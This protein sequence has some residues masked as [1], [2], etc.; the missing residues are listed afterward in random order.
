MKRF[1]NIVY[2]ADGSTA[3]DYTLERVVALANSNQ[4]SLTVVDVLENVDGEIFSPDV[5]TAQTRYALIE[6]RKEELDF[7]VEPYLDKH[8]LIY[9]KVVSGSAFI[10]VIKLV[11]NNHYD[12]VVKSARRHSQF[13][14]KVYGSIEMHLLRKCPCPVWIDKSQSLSPYRSILAAVDPE[15]EESRVCDEI[16]MQLSTSLAIREGAKLNI[17]HAWQI[18]GE[19]LLNSPRANFSEL[20]YEELKRS[21]L[22]RHQETMNQLLNQHGLSTHD[23]TVLLEHGRPAE[24]ILLAE[25]Q[26][27]ADLVVMGTIGRTGIPGLIIGNTAEDVLSSTN[28]SVLVVKPEGFESPVSADG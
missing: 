10:E 19:S 12:L 23:P 18:Y 15:T 2:F 14:K 22:N 28:A 11:L 27:H 24:V 4:A 3:P 26:L 13:F 7:M 8:S 16:I 5:I 9:T 25:Q 6:R 1:K 21:T 17:V 20:E